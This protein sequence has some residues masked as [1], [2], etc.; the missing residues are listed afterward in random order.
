MP[1][2]D[3]SSEPSGIGA[4]IA[5]ARNKWP[6]L[7]RVL[8]LQEH[9]SDVDGNLLAGGVTYFGF[10]SFFPV[11]ALGFATV[12]Y[13][14]FV[15]PQANDDLTTA[16]EQILPGIVSAEP[17]EGKLS[18]EQIQA[19]AATVGLVGLAGVLY[20]GLGWVTALRQGLTVAFRAP[21]AAKPNF[22]KGKITDLV[23]L[24]ILGVILIASVAVSSAVTGFAGFITDAL[25]IPGIVGAVLLGILGIG[26][27]VAASTVLFLAMY[28]IL[29][30]PDLPKR[31]IFAGALVAAIGFELLKN[32]AVLIL[33]GASGSAFASLALA[34]T[35][36]V[37]I[38]YFAR[39]TMYGAAWACTTERP[40]M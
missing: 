29:V 1:D 15:Y 25:R 10:L 36:L 24:A 33:G 35:L 27:G 18:L 34:I 2:K 39:L 4:K 22:I 5:R 8:R 7:D 16:I 11:L 12:G 23:T 17:A 3:D 37:W 31:H 26:L 19:S 14:S 20:A 6:W 9:Y 21:D 28:R 38:N 13:V 32:L 30:K 40:E